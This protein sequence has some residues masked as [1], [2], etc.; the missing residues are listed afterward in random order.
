[1]CGIGRVIAGAVVERMVAGILQQ[2]SRAN[3][4]L[5]RGGPASVL[6]FVLVP[7]VVSG[8]GGDLSDEVPN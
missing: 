4:Y 3:R 8:T 5:Q 7:S 1:M 2:G 6:K